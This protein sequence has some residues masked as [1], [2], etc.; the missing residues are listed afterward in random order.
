MF[1]NKLIS[2]FFICSFVN[3]YVLG[4][5]S[6]SDMWRRMIRILSSIIWMLRPTW[7]RVT[8]PFEL[9]R[10]EQKFSTYDPGWEEE[11]NS[12]KASKGRWTSRSPMAMLC[13]RITR[14]IFLAIGS[15][16]KTVVPYSLFR[17][18]EGVRA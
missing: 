4:V 11:E 13:R 8:S 7:R 10:L 2:V 9:N 3:R 5:D 18:A 6:V 1:T 14:A 17:L 16:Q 12:V 15:L